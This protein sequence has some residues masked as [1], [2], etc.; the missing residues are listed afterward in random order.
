MP[1]LTL[2]EILLYSISGPF[3][4]DY[5]DEFEED[6]VEPPYAIYCI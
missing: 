4:D 5:E 2:D 6:A 1:D 3:D